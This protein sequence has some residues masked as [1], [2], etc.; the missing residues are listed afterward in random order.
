MSISASNQQRERQQK[1]SEWQLTHW[2]R[3]TDWLSEQLAKWQWDSVTVWQTA[4]CTPWCVG[5]ECR[6][7][8][9]WKEIH[10]I[11]QLTNYVCDVKTCLTC[12]CL[13][14]SNT[15]REGDKDR[16]R[17]D[18]FWT[19]K[20]R[21]RWTKIKAFKSKNY[22]KL[23]S[24]WKIKGILRRLKIYLKY[25]WGNLVKNKFYLLIN[26]V[27]NYTHNNLFKY[28]FFQHNAPSNLWG[29]VWKNSERNVRKKHFAAKGKYRN[30]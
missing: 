8:K 6:L 10:C 17:V 4:R 1:Q 16:E 2:Q 19:R 14:I 28:V 26:C 20:E 30:H 5:W 11:N 3:L 25:K 15:E 22:A 12:W 9:R 21:K 7:V 23:K 18:A 27:T 29:N 24:K 13:F